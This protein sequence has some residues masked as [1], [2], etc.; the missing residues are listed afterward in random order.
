MNGEKW[1]TA[2]LTATIGSVVVCFLILLINESGKRGQAITWLP[3]SL[4]TTL[5]LT[6]MNTPDELERMLTC[7]FGSTLSSGVFIFSFATMISSF[8]PDKKNEF[9]EGQKDTCL[10]ITSIL[11]TIVP[12]AVILT[13]ET[14]MNKFWVLIA[15]LLGLGL[16]MY[17]IIISPEL[18]FDDN[19]VKF[20][21]THLYKY[22]K[23]CCKKITTEKH[24]QKEI[25]LLIGAV[26]GTFIFTITPAWLAD[27][28]H[29]NWAGVLA[30][31]PKITVLVMI[32]LYLNKGDTE[33]TYGNT[34]PEKEKKIKLRKE[35]LEHLTMFSYSTGITATYIIVLW[36]NESETNPEGF[37]RAWSAALA[38][39]LIFIILILVPV[40][41]KH[42]G[43]VSK[44]GVQSPP[45][46]VSTDEIVLSPIPAGSNLRVTSQ[47]Y[48]KLRW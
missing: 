39:S 34:V 30:N 8:L 9:N 23:K 42:R 14:Y 3:A 40:C 27:A 1:I 4:A 11:S 2:V 6:Y 12:A 46:N 37:W 43:E 24:E 20:K 19:V 32:S 38:L 41:R 36:F 28:G 48:P 45:R 26:L 35:L 16:I 25:N 44:S 22:L 18:I 33:D 21:I 15:G 10:F 7:A 17:T 13:I 31:M 29:P 5:A 47:G